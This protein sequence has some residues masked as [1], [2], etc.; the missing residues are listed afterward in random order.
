MPSD[1]LTLPSRQT[2][3]ATREA[4]LASHMYRE[5]SIHSMLDGDPIGV[6]TLPPRDVAQRRMRLV[7]FPTGVAT[8]PPWDN[9]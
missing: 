4:S 3:I 2:S 9:G 5:Q 8:L 7:R 1:V 6:T